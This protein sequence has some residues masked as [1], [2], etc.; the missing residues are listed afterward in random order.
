MSPQRSLYNQ[1]TVT[2]DST[3]IE[4]LPQL[5]SSFYG[6]EQLDSAIASRSAP[7]PATP[8]TP[9]PTLASCASW[10]PSAAPWKR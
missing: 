7:P 9:T 8:P 5:A 6:V 2:L 1:R 10:M 3:N 4:A